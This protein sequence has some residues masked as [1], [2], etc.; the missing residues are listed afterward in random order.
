MPIPTRSL[1]DTEL[2]LFIYG[3]CLKRDMGISK[4][5]I[6]SSAT[7]DRQVTNQDSAL[8]A[9]PVIINYFSDSS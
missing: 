5:P 8:E 4:T 7:W 9:P 2:Q 1:S 6:T 3:F